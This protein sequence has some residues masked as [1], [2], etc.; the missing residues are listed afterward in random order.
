M[1]VVRQSTIQT[2]VVSGA[3]VVV[4]A[5]MGGYGLLRF[6]PDRGRSAAVALLV[7]AAVLALVC[8]RSISRGTMVAVLRDTGLEIASGHFARWGLIRWDDVAE[9]FVFRSVGLRMIGLRM[10]EPRRY[11]ERSSMPARLSLRLDKLL[12]AGADAYVSAAAVKA[13]PTELGRLMRVFQ[14]SSAV[15]ERFGR[16]DVVLE[17]PTDVRLIDVLSAEPNRDE[18]DDS[19]DGPTGGRHEL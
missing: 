13:D 1:I 18:Q 10:I 6:D 5:A 4:F 7:V 8:I 9:I 19:R 16:D 2:S 17:F 15:R 3:L 11:L 14:R 12:A